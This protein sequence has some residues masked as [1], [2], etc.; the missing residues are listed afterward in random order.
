M[1]S[2]LAVSD[3]PF[4][5]AGYRAALEFRYPLT[6]ATN[7]AEALLILN[8]EQNIGLL[9]CDYN[10][11][12]HQINGLELVRKANKIKQGIMAIVT[13]SHTPASLQSQLDQLAKDG[14]QVILYDKS[15]GS[16]GMGE[17]VRDIFESQQFDN[18]NI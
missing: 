10:L 4:E 7:P 12:R 17:L 2:I 16:Q 5:I 1:P 6:T 9:V 18:R 8:G 14:V 3:E 13:T 15:R 11:G